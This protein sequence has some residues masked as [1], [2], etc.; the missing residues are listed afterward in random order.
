M[1]KKN[2]AKS[3]SNFE[4]IGRSFFVELRAAGRD[5]NTGA[6]RESEIEK[7]K[8][9]SGGS[10]QRKWSWV[11]GVRGGFRRRKAMAR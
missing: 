7:Y 8:A 4:S 6:R 1:N 11:E 2:E 10:A 3:A 9:E 5:T